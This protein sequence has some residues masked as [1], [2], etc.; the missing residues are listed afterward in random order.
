M[1]AERSLLAYL[2]WRR[3]RGLWLVWVGAGCAESGGRWLRWSWVRLGLDRI[4]EVT[5]G[6]QRLMSS[7]V[8]GW[9]RIN[10]VGITVCV[11]VDRKWVGRWCVVAMVDRLMGGGVYL[12]MVFRWFVCPI[13]WLNGVVLCMVW[14]G[15]G[16]AYGRICMLWLNCLTSVTVVG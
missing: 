13:N 2:V 15:E 1:E 10:N 12:I 6:S 11:D 16:C 8:G 5:S 14:S 9:V 7:G 3:R 4:W